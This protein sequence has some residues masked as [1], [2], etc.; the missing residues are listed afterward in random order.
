MI[1][2]FRNPI[3]KARDEFM[4]GPEGTRLCDAL[5][6]GAPARCGL[7]LRDRIEAAFLAGWNACEQEMAAA[8][9]ALRDVGVT[10]S[11]ED[12]VAAVAHVK[13]RYPESVFPS[14]GQ[15]S[16][17]RAAFMA[18]RTCDNIERFAADRAKENNRDS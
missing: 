13:A 8:V 16:D 1:A 17:C 18:R 3:A 14:T 6:I 2:D 11:A 7:Y 10:P 5:G 9:S 12:W 15:S 4:L